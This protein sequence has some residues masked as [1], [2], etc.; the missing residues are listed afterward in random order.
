MKEIKLQEMKNS[1]HKRKAFNFYIMCMSN[2]NGVTS[3]KIHVNLLHMGYSV[4]YNE[5]LN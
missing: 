5:D 1:S 2:F 3:Q 4:V